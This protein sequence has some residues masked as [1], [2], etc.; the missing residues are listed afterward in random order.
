[1]SSES[2]STFVTSLFASLIA[3]AGTSLDS[4]PFGEAR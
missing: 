4:G 1:L 2:F 3:M